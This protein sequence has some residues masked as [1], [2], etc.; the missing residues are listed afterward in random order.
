MDRAVQPFKRKV[1]DIP[2]DTFRFLSIKA[3]GKG[4]NLKKYIES[5]L[6]KDVED[7]ENL[8]DSS[9]YAYLMQ[10]RP[11]GL[12]PADKEEQDEFCKWLKQ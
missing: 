10:N 5:L 3:A 8:D 4:M 9:L 1:I 7:L 2:A 12:V 11:D 6:Q